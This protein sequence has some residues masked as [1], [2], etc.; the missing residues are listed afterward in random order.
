M[1]GGWVSAQRRNFPC[2]SSRARRAARQKL[3]DKIDPIEARL[4]ERDA[5]WKA[6]RERLTF[7][8]ATDKFLAVHENG[9]RNPK[10][11]KQWRSTLAEHAFPKLGARPVAAID[12]ALIN[13]AVAS[14]WTS[15]P[16]TARRVRG[17][18]ERIVQWVKDGMP[19]PSAGKNGKRNHPALPYSELPSFMAELRARDNISARALEFRS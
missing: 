11:R 9:W 19:L 6:D 13:D 3:A 4:A 16:E 17:R 18:I 5:A 1:N 14:I 12:T 2:R 8:A 10:H 15:T 7:K